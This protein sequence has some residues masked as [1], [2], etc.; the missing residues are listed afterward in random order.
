MMSQVST[1]Q[2][3]PD[4]QARN[5][6]YDDLA[7][8]LQTVTTGTPAPPAPATTS[9]AG[10]TKAT[11]HH[12]SSSSTSTT[13][14]TTTTSTTT[15]STTPYVHHV[16]ELL[17]TNTS[18]R[19]TN[20]AHSVFP[21]INTVTR[22]RK[23]IKRGFVLLNGDKVETSRFVS[24]GDIVT[25]DME[26]LTKDD[27]EKTV[28]YNFSIPVVYED[29]HIA[30][31]HKP[32]GLVTNGDRLR[33][34]EHALSSNLKKSSEPDAMV[35]Q[36]VHRLDLATGGLVCVAKTRSARIMLGAE[37][38]QRNVQ[39]RY[40]AIVVGRVEENEGVCIMP[41]GNKESK[42]EWKV[43]SR[44]K[45]L[46]TEWITTLDLYPKTGR[47][48]QLRIH[49]AQEIGGGGKHP[50]VGDKMYTE[51]K[52]VLCHHKGMFLR[53]LVREH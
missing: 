5:R 9:N 19:M 12:Q 36:P 1:I 51:N 18:L 39:K 26:A 47:K 17:P 44:T 8:M 49:C 23:L 33:S 10:E 2:N 22:A 37:F 40:R 38:E 53:A 31:V 6:A 41:I 24:A 21:S 29:E 16:P 11:D 25:I 14:T 20:Y 45:S 15:T 13:T 42:T 52:H 43:I 50:I 7:A 35:P 34:L 28:V 30:V 3:Q 27:L 32:A 48:H 46:H 4:E